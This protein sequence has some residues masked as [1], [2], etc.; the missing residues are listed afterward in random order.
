MSLFCGLRRTYDNTKKN[1]FGAASTN[2]LYLDLRAG[3]R[4][5][6][7]MDPNDEAMEATMAMLLAAIS[8]V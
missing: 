6:H 1:S 5:N 2:V 7:R 8:C 3:R 4:T